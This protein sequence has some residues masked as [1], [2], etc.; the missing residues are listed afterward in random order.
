MQTTFDLT[1]AQ[2]LFDSSEKFPVDF[3]LAWKWLG[4]SRKDNALRSFLSMEFESETD[5]VILLI[6][7]EYSDRSVG[8]PSQD[9]RLTVDCLK[10]FAMM[11]KTEA[12]KQVRRYFLDCEKALKQLQAAPT[13]T[14]IALPPVAVQVANLAD[15]LKF[16]DIDTSNP[17][18]KQGL[19]DIVLNTLGIAQTSLPGSASVYLGV[20]EK[21]ERLG[22]PVGLVTKHRSALGKYVKA[23]GLESVKEE[24]LCNGTARPINVYLDCHELTIAVC[25]FM[26]A[27]TLATANGG[28]I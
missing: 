2:S 16:F 25:E 19:Q 22:Y 17:R 20:A 12:G 11:A 23:S 3:D 28:S 5:F 6:N 24:R 8:Q 9:Y 1:I 7:E 26:D 15:A 27:K 13:P 10:T 14:P 18:L 4:Y 21:A